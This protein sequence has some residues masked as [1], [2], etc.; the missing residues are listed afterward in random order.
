MI[1][2]RHAAAVFLTGA[3]VL[4]GGAASA[5][6]ESAKDKAD[7][8]APAAD[9]TR[10]T[11]KNSAKTLTIRTKLHKASAGRTHVVATLTPAA[12]GA[13]A[14]VARTVDTG[15]GAKVGAVLETTAA[16]ATEPAAVDCAGLKASVSSGRAGQVVIRVPQSCFGDAAGTVTVAVATATADGDVAD[17]APELR[18]KRG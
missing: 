8:A 16:D 17:E 9:I 12:E 2:S 14:Y 4:T 7:D 18:V 11:V 10:V 13:A 6:R 3:L 15:R 1:R 5:A